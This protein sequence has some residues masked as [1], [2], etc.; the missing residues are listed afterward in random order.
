MALDTPPKLRRKQNLAFGA[1]T[2]TGT[3][4]SLS[5]SNGVTNIFNPQCEFNTET[6]ERQSQ[7]NLSPIMQGLGARAARLRFETELVGAGTSGGTPS[8]MPLFQA[9]GCQFSSPNVTPLT[10]SIVTL[11]MGLYVDG[12]FRLVSGCQGTGVVKL[13]RGQQVRVAWDF[14]GVQQPTTDVS[15]ITPTYV[16]TPVAPRAGSTFTFATQSLRLADIDFDLGN[17]VIL[18]ED[19][20]AVDSAGNPTG[21]RNAYITNRKATMKFAPEAL[22]IATIDLANL[23]NTSVL[24]ALS[25]QIGSTANNQFTLT[26]PKVQITEYP[27]MGDRQGLYVEN[28]TGLCT[29]NTP[30]GDDEWGIALG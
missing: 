25:L 1:E 23:Y 5:S 11:T 4:L 30:L 10:G 16:T 28:I 7:G 17:Q 18:R 29:R 24:S 19:I 21:Y 13:R 9:C 26:A 20:G 12:R 2:T 15:I 27:G 6:V 8:W 3:P 22:P 14:M